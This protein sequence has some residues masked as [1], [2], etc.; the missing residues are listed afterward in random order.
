M[1]E[2]AMEVR[3][4]ITQNLLQP[5]L[6]FDI[7]VA[8]KLAEDGGAFDRLISQAIQLAEQRNSADFAH[9]I[10]PPVRSYSL[11]EIPGSCFRGKTALLWFPIPVFAG[12]TLSCRLRLPG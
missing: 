12:M 5:V 4:L 3:V 8:A 6:E 9:A 1:L 7:W 2:D 10:F 11:E